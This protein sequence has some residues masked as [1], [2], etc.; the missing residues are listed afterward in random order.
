GNAFLAQI[1]T[2]A[3]RAE[4]FVF[5]A[6][7]GIGLGVGLIVEIFLF[8]QARDDGGDDLL[9][10]LARLYALVHEASQLGLRAHAAAQRLDGVVVEAGFVEKLARLRRFA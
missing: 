9:S 6:Q 3:A 7:S 1:L 2:D 10:A 5:L 4:L 8:F